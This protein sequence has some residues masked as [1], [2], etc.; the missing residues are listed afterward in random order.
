M[1]YLHH[2]DGE[3]RRMRY[4]LSVALGLHLVLVSVVSFN[5]F[6]SSSEARQ[7]E[8]TLATSRA[9]RAPDDARQLAQQNQVGSGDM[10][11]ED[12][13][14]SP[15][16]SL[17]PSSPA[18]QQAAPRAE[19]VQ[20]ASGELLSTVAAAPRAVTPREQREHMADSRGLNPEARDREQANAALLAAP[21]ERQREMSTQPRVRR[22][23]SV[24]AKQAA[25]A[26]YL[27]DWRQRLEAVGNRYY[28]E[29]SIRYGLYGDLRL[30]V[31][32]RSDGS[33]EDVEILK[34]SGY[35]VLDEAAIKI[36]RMAAP[37]SEFPPELAATTDKLEIVRTWQFSEQ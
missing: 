36:V 2:I 28:P 10:A 17:P 8:V 1:Y 14:T 34:S 35:A 21:D 9:E 23:T 3:R 24:S 15:Q 4:A 32:I 18:Q 20:Q 37:Y 25:D 22:L 30:M 33:L 7:I 29:A 11:R 19:T 31:V 12:A 16:S 27:L 13:V 6:G 5:N 26:A